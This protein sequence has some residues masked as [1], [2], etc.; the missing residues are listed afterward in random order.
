M[1]WKFPTGSWVRSSPAI[2]LDGTLYVGSDDGKL[3]A[4]RDW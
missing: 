3:Y 1:R 4:F 2:G